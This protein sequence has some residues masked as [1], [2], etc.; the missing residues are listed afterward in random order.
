MLGGKMV[1]ALFGAH[2]V[3]RRSDTIAAGGSN[4]MSVLFIEE[5]SGL[6]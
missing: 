2:A 1:S 5:T 3:T 4:L 6:F